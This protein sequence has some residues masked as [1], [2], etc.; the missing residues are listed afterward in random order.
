MLTIWIQ[1]RLINHIHIFESVI[2]ISC[3]PFQLISLFERVSQFFFSWLK[4]KNES[5][6]AHLFFWGSLRGREPI[7]KHLGWKQ[8]IAGELSA[9]STPL[10]W[11]KSLCV[12]RGMVPWYYFLYLWW[13]YKPNFSLLC[14]FFLE[15]PITT[16]WTLQDNF[17]KHYTTSQSISDYFS[18]LKDENETAVVTSSEYVPSLDKLICGCEDGTIFITQALNAAKAGLL[19]GGSLLKGLEFNLTLLIQFA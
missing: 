19:E 9:Y 16:T 13:I 6:I 3:T 2:S 5:T 11:Q 18:G 4:S 12:P 17:D 7:K 1:G 15:I 10:G 8:C 14:V